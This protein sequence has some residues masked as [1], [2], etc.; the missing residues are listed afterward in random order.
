MERIFNSVINHA[1]NGRKYDESWNGLTEWSNI[2]NSYN[3]APSIKQWGDQ[4]STDLIKKFTNHILTNVI[5]F[6]DDKKMNEQ[7]HFLIQCVRIPIKNEFTDMRLYQI[8]YNIGQL[9]AKNDQLDS[10]DLTNFYE[11]KLDQFRTY[12]DM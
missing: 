8:A 1:Y 4:L 9:K 10:T 2:K 11:L 5:E 12:Y 7:A 6:D 3:N